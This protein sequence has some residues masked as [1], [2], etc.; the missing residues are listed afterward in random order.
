MAQGRRISH[1]I[2]R[3]IMPQAVGATLHALAERGD[4][5]AIRAAIHA[6]EFVNATDQYGNTPLIVAAKNG[7]TAAALALLDAGA[8]VGPKNIAGHTAA[9]AAAERGDLV[10]LK[11]LVAAGASVE[12]RTEHGRTPIMLAASRDRVD[13][14]AWLMFEGHADWDAEDREGKTALAF[15]IET[16]SLGVRS[17]LEEAN[18]RESGRLS[19]VRRTIM[20]G[21][22]IGKAPPRLASQPEGFLISLMLLAAGAGSVA[23]FVLSRVDGVNQMAV[24]FGGAF[25]PTAFVLL[26]AGR[27]IAWRAHPSGVLSS[28]ITGMVTAGFVLLGLGWVGVSVAAGDLVEDYLFAASRFV[29]N[30]F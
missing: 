6:H 29:W 25:L 5:A 1:N 23:A 28:A 10:L 12:A 22:F 4:V 3:F 20:F 24:G 27:L 2:A 26:A 14:V 8:R 18:A 11:R 19:L 15:A 16:D 7:Q 13:V 30:L 17:L 21:H 9:H